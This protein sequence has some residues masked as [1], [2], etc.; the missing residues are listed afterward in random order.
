[1][2]AVHQRHT[3][4]RLV[5]D[6]AHYDGTSTPRVV[7]PPPL[8]RT[9]AK[10]MELAT[11]PVAHRS[12]GSAACGNPTC[13]APPA[14][15]RPTTARRSRCASFVEARSRSP[16]IDQRASTFSRFRSPCQPKPPSIGHAKA[17]Q[18]KRVRK[19][20]YSHRSGG[21]ALVIW[22]WLAT[23]P[24]FRYLAARIAMPWAT[25]RS[26]SAGMSRLACHVAPGA[27]IGHAQPSG[28]LGGRRASARQQGR[29]RC[30]T[31]VYRKFR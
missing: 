11:A 15:C 29:R 5:I 7:A 10:I 14:W 31:P 27:A 19:A 4:A 16:M 6:P 9:G 26:Q 8:G 12:T 18:W 2:L 17:L 1:M 28:T 30:G 22:P 25:V 23:T 21:S 13:S 20:L 3:P 24:A